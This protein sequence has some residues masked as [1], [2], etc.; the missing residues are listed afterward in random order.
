MMIP[1]L[2][3]ILMLCL[4]AGCAGRAGTPANPLETLQA[5]NLALTPIQ[6]IAAEFRS[7]RTVQGHFDGGPWNDEVDKWMGRKHQLMIELGARLGTGEYSRAQ[8][9]AWLGPPD[10]T[11]HQGDDL[12][13]QVTGLTNFEQPAPGPYELLLYHWRGTHDFLYF[14]AQQET[15][16]NAGW[17]YAGE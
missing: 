4:L 14:I 16:V 10:A 9:I 13:A 15:V 5:G 11:I 7:L 1:R 6:D 12:F 17:W 3:A 2:S 8:L